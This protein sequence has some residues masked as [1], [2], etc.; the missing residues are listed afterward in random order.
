MYLLLDCVIVYISAGH[1][2]ENEDAR[3]IINTV[4]NNNR[5]F[6]NRA[7]VMTYAL[8]QG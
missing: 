2:S 5:L 4:I 7:I 1:I 6:N 3:A 8:V